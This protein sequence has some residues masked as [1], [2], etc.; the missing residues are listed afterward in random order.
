MGFRYR[1]S[2]N[3]G[4]GFRVN[5]NTK[6]IGY[7]WGTKGYRV[8]KAADGR[9]R[10]TV[11]IPGTGI[12]YVDE[13][14][15]KRQQSNDSQHQFADINAGYSEITAVKSANIAKLRSSEYDELFRQ[16]KTAKVLRITAVVV[17]LLSTSW[18]PSLFPFF[19]AFTAFLFFKSRS[20][21]E[22][23]FDHAQLAKWEVLSAAWQAV[24]SSQSLQEITTT[25]K[26]KNV[27]VTAGIENAV[28]TVKMTANS[29]LPWYL[30]TNITP[31][32]FNF[33]NY[34]LAIMP[35]RLLVIG[36]KRLGA[37][38]YSDIRFDITAVGFLETGALPND[39][40]MVKQVWAYANK[41]G[42]ADKRYSS[43]TQ[44]PIMKYGQICISSDSELNIQFLCS[45][46]SAADALNRI[47]NG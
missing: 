18:V 32:V 36:K 2:I 15:A 47:I 14:N 31:I 16:I 17:T 1:K 23:E 38:A 34:R 4:G 11:T 33:Q 22:Y 27:R 30:R 41:D 8:T 3:L 10:Q 39:A 20:Y 29:K 24:A 43:N 7:S 40:E 9:T 5:L 35:D 28:D 46:E 13:H 12:S 26:S 6:G 25:A 37:L 45:N 44:F 19:V 42:S 21:I